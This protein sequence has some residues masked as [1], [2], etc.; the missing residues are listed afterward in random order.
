MERMDPVT[1]SLDWL[2][3]GLYNFFSMMFVEKESHMLHGIEL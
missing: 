1:I 2:T 3:N